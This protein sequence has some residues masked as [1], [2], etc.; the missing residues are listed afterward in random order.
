MEMFEPTRS[1]LV[2]PAHTIC[3][4]VNTFMRQLHLR[5]VGSPMSKNSW[6][7]PARTTAKSSAQC[8][9]SGAEFVLRSDG[10]PKSAC[11]VRIRLFPI[12]FRQVAESNYMGGGAVCL[13]M[14]QRGGYDCPPIRVRFEP[15]F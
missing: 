9:S 2:T 12:S 8:A 6:K 10:G 3:P 13:W 7:H 15:S 4:L 1:C 5:G 11:S 14:A